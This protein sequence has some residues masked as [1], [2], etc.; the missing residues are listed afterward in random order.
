MQKHSIRNWTIHLE[1]PKT[2]HVD[3]TR[4]ALQSLHTLR[5]SHEMQ[6]MCCCLRDFQWYTCLIGKVTR[7]QL[8]TSKKGRTRQPSGSPDVPFDLVTY[9]A[10]AFNSTKRT[11][12]MPSKVGPPD[13]RNS[14]SPS[15]PADPPTSSA[16]GP[17]ARALKG[18][19]DQAL[20]HT[21]GKCTYEN[22]ASCFP[23]PAKH[24]PEALNGL[25]RDF[26]TR[27]D[28]MCRVST[29]LDI[30]CSVTAVRWQSIA[31]YLIY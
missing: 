24:V 30:P 11:A 17:R 18:M 28:E 31:F 4:A 22:F 21:L 14:P 10:L 20:S 5:L 12:V 1:K 26:V 6:E 16:P 8:F 25:H 15:P 27:L 9:A 3:I 19:F 2:P 7:P 13:S 29:A 23:T